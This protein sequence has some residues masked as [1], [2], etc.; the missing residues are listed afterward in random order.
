[1]CVQRIHK[2][3]GS[4]THTLLYFDPYSSLTTYI[5]RQGLV[6]AAEVGTYRF[7]IVGMPSIAN[8]KREIG[9]SVQN[10]DN[11]LKRGDL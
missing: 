11:G 6:G 3:R 10:N 8:T 1:V 5:R 4:L 2:N 7:F 9:R